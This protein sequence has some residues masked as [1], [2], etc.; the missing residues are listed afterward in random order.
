MKRVAESGDGEHVRGPA[1]A[2]LTLI[3]YAD[4]QCPYSARAELLERRHRGR[5]RADAERARHDGAA[6]TPTFTINGMRY[7]G[8]SDRASLERALSEALGR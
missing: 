8:D 5:V 3:E 6:A 2:A 4:F 1:D 7:R